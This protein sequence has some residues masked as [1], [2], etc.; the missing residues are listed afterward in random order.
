MTM[1]LRSWYDYPQYYD[2]AFRDETK[3]EADFFEAAFSKFAVGRVHRLLEPACGSG[4]LVAAMARRGYQLE[5]F[6]LSEPSLKYLRRRLRRRGL[7][8]HVFQAD[9]TDFSL[10][11]PVDA[12]FCTMNT[13]RHLLTERA[14]KAHLRSVARAVRPGG[15][16]ILGLHVFPPD[17]DNE[18]VERWTAKH[19]STR[20]TVTLRARPL[21]LKKRLEQIDISMRVRTP[22]ENFRLRND[23]PLRTYTAGQLRR[24]IRSVP[25]WETLAVY[26]FWYE[27]D[28]PVELDEEISDT[29]LVLRRR[30]REA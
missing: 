24:L 5:A 30:D 9:M 6:D 2:L 1:V 3:R 14:A 22:R 21:D 18:C 25:A 17:A 12:A 20:V 16:Y 29:V 27:I 23:F 15:L 19:G 4:R 10:D 13:V 28:E 26:D 7:E 11:A 8:A